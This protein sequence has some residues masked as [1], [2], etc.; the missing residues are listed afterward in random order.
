MSPTEKE[1]AV[2]SRLS[3]WKTAVQAELQDLISQ[4]AEL[5]KEISQAKTATKRKYY[6][7]KFEK[8]KP[9]VMQMVAALQKLEA[10]D[11]DTTPVNELADDSIATA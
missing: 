5:R 1:Q 7:K 6:E 10:V 11:V 9:R 3:Q 8:I 4:A 2:D